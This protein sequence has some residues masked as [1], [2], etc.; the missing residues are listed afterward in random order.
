MLAV[1]AARELMGSRVEDKTSFTTGS[2]AGR[3]AGRA[4]EGTTEP[5]IRRKVRECMKPLQVAFHHADVDGTG[6]V[7]HRALRN[8]LE[9]HDIMLPDP[10]WQKLITKMDAVSHG[11]CSKYGLSFNRP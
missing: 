11:P 6:E 8:I 1:P 5:Q 7:S 4:V 9:S 3:G 2:G 10:Q